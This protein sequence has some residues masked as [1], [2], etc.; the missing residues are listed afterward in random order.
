[1]SNYHDFGLKQVWL[2]LESS[3]GTGGLQASHHQEW[4]NPPWLSLL[5]SLEPNWRHC[6]GT[7]SFLQMEIEKSRKTSL[8]TEKSVC[9]FYHGIIEWLALK[10][11]FKVIWFPLLLPWAHG[12]FPLD[13][14]AQSSIQPDL[15]HFQYE[16]STASLDNLFSVVDFST[17]ASVHCSCSFCY[18]TKHRKGL[19]LKIPTLNFPYK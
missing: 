17:S 5:K 2:R 18:S 13:L 19:A 15:E 10:W 7:T 3:S 1:M 6:E 16:G 12:H 8:A 9:T 11:S 4:Q 14:A